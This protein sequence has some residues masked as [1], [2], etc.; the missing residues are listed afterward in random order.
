MPELFVGL[1]ASEGISEL[2]L[3]VAALQAHTAA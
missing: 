1:A 3:V 2:L